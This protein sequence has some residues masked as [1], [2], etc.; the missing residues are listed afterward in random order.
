MEFTKEPIKISLQGRPHQVEFIRQNL[1]GNTNRL[2]D[3]IKRNA[4]LM[5]LGNFIDVFLAQHVSG[6]YARHQEH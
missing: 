4:S 3:E 1:L 5:Q 2:S 6:T